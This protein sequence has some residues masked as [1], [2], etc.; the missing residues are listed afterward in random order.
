[1]HDAPRSVRDGLFAAPL[2]GRAIASPAASIVVAEWIDPGG[3]GHPPNYIAPLH[4]HHADDEAWYVIDGALRVRIDEEDV[5]VPAGGGVLV[6]R[7]TVHTFWN[8]I[9]APTRYLLIMTPRIHRLID[10]L[11]EATDMTADELAAAFRAHDS[12][13]LG[14]P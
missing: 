2:A 14:W 10:L 5:E 3:G 9:S 12:E 4:V 11:H 6:P 13:F 7:G 8:P 1:V